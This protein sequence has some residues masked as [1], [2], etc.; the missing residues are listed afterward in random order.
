MSTDGTSANALPDHGGDLDPKSEEMEQHAFLM[1]GK[2]SL[3]GC[4]MTMF[5]HEGHCYQMVLRVTLPDAAMKK[6]RDALGTSRPV[7]GGALPETLFLANSAK[8]RFSI[9]QLQSGRRRSFLADIYQGVPARQKNEGWPWSQKDPADADKHRTPYL[10]VEDIVVEVDRVVF[11][12]HFDF[13][14]ERPR[15]LTYVLFGEGDEAHMTN[16]QI[17]DPDFDHVLSLES[18]PG[19]L[20]ESKLGAG[21]QVTFNIDSRPGSQ[22]VHCSN[23]LPPGRYHVQYQG[24]GATAYEV[25]VAKTWWFST[26][27]VNKTDP[28]A[29][30]SGAGAGHE[31]GH[32]HHG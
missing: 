23:P 25:N 24:Q 20:P 6:Y 5:D 30:T 15:K 19:W 28:C 27:I 10:L 31:G 11:A 26:A 1:L 16:Y 3:F 29:A 13:G 32:H 9:P 7:P 12:R 17:K 8:D 21:I 2:Q 22:H 4:H 14:L 18:P